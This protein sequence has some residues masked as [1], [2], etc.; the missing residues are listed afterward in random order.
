MLVSDD[1]KKDTVNRGIIMIYVKEAKGF[2]EG[3]GGI[4]PMKGSSDAY[5]TFSWGKFGKTISSTRIIEKDQNPEW[6]EWAYMLVSPEEINADEKLKSSSGT[7]TN[8][9]P[10]TTWDESKFL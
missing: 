1:F 9:Q 5:V 7:A 10:T 2:K 4:G 8:F 3:D 6:H